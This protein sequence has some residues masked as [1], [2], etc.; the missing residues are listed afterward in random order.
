MADETTTGAKTEVSVDNTAAEASKKKM[1]KTII[2]VV[3]VAV[4]AFVVWKY[5]IKK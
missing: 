2:I 5:V 3:V 1:I 4:I